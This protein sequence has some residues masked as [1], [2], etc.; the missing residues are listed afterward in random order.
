M[1]RS[2]P[3][4]IVC[5]ALIALLALYAAPAL[6]WS[7]Q[8]HRM[9]G[10]LA[11]RQLSPQAQAAVAQLLIGEAEP[12]LAGVASWA[13]DLRDDPAWRHAA[14]WHYINF[15]RPHDGQDGCAYVPARDCTDGDCVIGAIQAQAAIL[16][17]DQKPRQKRIEAL[18]FIVHFVG[19]VHQ[20][21]HAG[22]GDDRGGNDYQ[23]SLRTDIAPTAYNRDQYR[24]GVQGTNLHAVWDFYLLASHDRDAGRYAAE[25]AARPRMDAHDAAR[26]MPAEWAL[27]SCRMVRDAALYPRGHKL[28]DAY[29]QRQRPLAERRVIQAG[30]RLAALL[31]DA[32][33]DRAPADGTAR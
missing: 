8:G 16:A 13:D 23:I 17:D 33:G 28:G 19:D 1:V 21:L 11:Q 10:D 6:A 7:A 18:K 22:Y 9:V 15:P 29:L 5:T 32:L 25:L 27:E 30:Q 31:N 24:D 20:P 4:R 2:V 26:G 12:T 14:R 3:S